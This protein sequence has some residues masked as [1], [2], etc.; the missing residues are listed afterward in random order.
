MRLLEREN[1]PILA[2]L[3]ARV[4][5][6]VRFYCLA[7]VI[8]FGGLVE[9]MVNRG[10]AV[11][12]AKATAMQKLY[13]F[14]EIDVAPKNDSLYESAVGYAISTLFLVDNGDT[15]MRVKFMSAFL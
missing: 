5:L 11:E 8:C 7:L 15:T 6:Q 10:V 12:E 4:C 13:D 3:L 14:L 9:N 1:L 2:I